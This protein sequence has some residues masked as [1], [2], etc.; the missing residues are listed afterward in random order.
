M[1]FSRRSFFFR[2]SGYIPLPAL[3]LAALL[4]ALPASAATTE[5]ELTPRD[6][7][8]LIPIETRG[9]APVYRLDLPFAV[10]ERSRLSPLR[11][12]R[13]FNSL[14]QAEAIYI[15]T[16]EALPEP[17]QEDAFPCFSQRVRVSP[18]GVVLLRDGQ[19]TP[20]PKP[21]HDKSEEYETRALLVDFDQ[22]R[23]RFDRVRLV[24]GETLSN[25]AA[26]PDGQRGSMLSTRLYVSRDLQHWSLAARPSLGR[27]RVDGQNLEMLDLPAGELDQRYMLLVPAAGSELFPVRE[28]LAREKVKSATPVQSVRLHGHKDDKAGGFGYAV[29]RGLPVLNL[30][31]ELGSG[32]ILLRGSILT[33]TLRE[34]SKARH[35]TVRQRSE[36]EQVWDERAPLFYYRL[37]GNGPDFRHSDPVPFDWN[38]LSPENNAPLLRDA[39]FTLLL[40]LQGDR[41]EAPALLVRWARQHLYFMAEGPGPYILAVGSL[42]AGEAADT[43]DAALR[44][45]PVQAAPARLE[46]DKLHAQTPPTAYSETPGCQ[47]WLLWGVLLLGAACM[48]FMAVQLLRKPRI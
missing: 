41:T 42:K 23:P 46:M 45:L 30:E 18:G 48:A 17:T 2:L 31:P 35:L 21:G 8:T 43:Q 22:K 3:A 7:S 34:I 28:L 33:P 29:P 14:G 44:E 1:S 24:P 25:S 15:N 13:V 6:F 37:G 4:T 40:R 9:S 20:A 12:V 10:Y 26:G 19:T 27:L 16:A 11:D 5:Q 39:P 32:N 36:T 38:W 47:R